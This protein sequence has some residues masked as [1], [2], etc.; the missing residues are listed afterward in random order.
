MALVQIISTFNEMLHF[1]ISL[2]SRSDEDDGGF[3]DAAQIEDSGSTNCRFSCLFLQRWCSLIEAGRAR[4]QFFR[5]RGVKDIDE[6]A[7]GLE[8][9]R[10]RPT[11]AYSI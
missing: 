7:N 10:A 8:L 4:L 6:Q 5:R 11:Q 2:F 3:G 9:Q 1:V